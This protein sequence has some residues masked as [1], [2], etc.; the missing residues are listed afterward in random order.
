MLAA[1]HLQSDLPLSRDT[2][3]PSKALRVVPIRLTLLLCHPHPPRPA[4]VQRPLVCP[5]PLRRK[6]SSRPSATCIYVFLTPVMPARQ[7]HRWHRFSPHTPL[8]LALSSV[9][10]LESM[11][12]RRRARAQLPRHTRWLPWAWF[13][14]RQSGQHIPLHSLSPLVKQIPL[15][16]LQQ[17]MLQLLWLARCGQQLHL[18]SQ[19]QP[20]V[21]RK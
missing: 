21:Q 11:Q 17:K 2:L 20:I 10:C 12:L 1:C 8:Y 19:P 13:W 15:A 9:S 14:T 7:L 5:P 16:G 4:P 3:M 6:T 18:D